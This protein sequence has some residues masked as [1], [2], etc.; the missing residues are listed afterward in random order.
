MSIIYPFTKQA[1]KNEEVFMSFSS[2]FLWIDMREIAIDRGI[3]VPSLYRV[4]I[5]SFSEK[6]NT[7]N[8][9]TLQFLALIIKFN[10]AKKNKCQK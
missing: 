5:R 9:Y 6:I 7:L 10:D 8:K 3:Q 1:N 2:I 4:K